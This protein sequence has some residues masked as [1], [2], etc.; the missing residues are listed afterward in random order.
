MKRVGDGR[1]KGNGIK[2]HNGRGAKPAARL[3][4]VQTD[5]GVLISGEPAEAGVLGTKESHDLDKAIMGPAQELAQELDLLAKCLER[6]QSRLAPVKGPRP[7]LTSKDWSPAG[8][9]GADRSRFLGLLAYDPW[10]EWPHFRE[11]KA[12]P[13]VDRGEFAA[14]IDGLSKLVAKKQQRLQSFYIEPLL[15][16]GGRKGG[17]PSEEWKDA[18][19]AIYEQA[20]RSHQEIAAALDVKESTPAAEPSAR[21]VEQRIRRFYERTPGLRKR[22]RPNT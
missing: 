12:P 15:R 3:R 21:G 7:R 1:A 14:A 6:V 13:D 20:G 5:Q 8:L 9:A 19:A 4:P 16:K 22:P 2:R 11:D 18:L 17:R 10:H